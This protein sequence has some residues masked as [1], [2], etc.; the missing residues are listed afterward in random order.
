[1]SN[2]WPA[3][4]VEAL[5][6]RR[7][8]MPLFTA[9][10]FAMLPF[11]GGFFMVILKDPEFARRVGLISAKAQL[12]M[13]TADWPTYLGFLAQGT[14]VGGMFLF[15]MVSIWAFGREFSDR[16]IKDLLAL[17]TAR[18]AIV[19]AKFVIATAW[20]LVLTAEVCLLGLVVGIALRL[21]PV[22]VHVIEQ[23]VVTT[24]VAA[25]LTMLLVTPIALIAC[26]GHGY[27]PPVGMMILLVVLAQVSVIIGRGEY[28]PWAIPALYTQSE[29]LGLASIALVILTSIGGVVST[30][31]WWERADQTR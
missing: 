27:L 25:G 14:A 17:P 11:G 12:T 21:P 22:P 10:A 7:S 15:S 18:P 9:L 1:M 4:W 8:K 28:F 20:S 29:P 23:G 30:V 13:G 24:A 16:T 6:A 5:K 19:L 26:A 2:L 31:G 3:I